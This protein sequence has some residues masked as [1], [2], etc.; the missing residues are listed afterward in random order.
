MFI[1]FPHLKNHS[2]QNRAEGK[3]WCW[4][5]CMFI[6]FNKTWAWAYGYCIWHLSHSCFCTSVKLCKLMCLKPYLVGAHVQPNLV[7]ETHVVQEKKTFVS[8]SCVITQTFQAH[9]LWSSL[10]GR[11]MKP[12]SAMKHPAGIAPLLLPFPQPS[13]TLCSFRN[14][15]GLL[16]VSRTI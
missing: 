7:P 8:W 6:G 16:C 9:T 11:V 12:V 5:F 10:P 14:L 15:P 4:L 2:L 1:F 3:G 13:W